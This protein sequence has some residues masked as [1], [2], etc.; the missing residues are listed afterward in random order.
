M[1]KPLIALVAA[2]TLALPAG[3]ALVPSTA[4][5][6]HKGKRCGIVGK[7]SR[8]YRVK[9]QKVRCSYARKWSRRY[10][11]N[12]KKPRH[13]RCYRPGGK[14]PFYCKRGSKAYWVER[15]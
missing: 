6:M 4:M 12:R 2:G 15:L 7:G 5:A 14:I 3:G 9:A 10:L 11:K 8:D 1:R 13:W